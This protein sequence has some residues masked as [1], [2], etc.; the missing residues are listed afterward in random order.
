MTEATSAPLAGIRVA[1]FTWAWAGPHGTLLLAML[2]AEVIKIE[3]RTRL[4]HARVRSLMTGTLQSGPDASP[5]FNDLNLGKLSLSLNLRR[6]EAREVVRRLVA[7]SDVVTENM[8]PGVLDRL[9]L[10]YQDLRAVKPD[11]IML[12]S[13]AVGATGPESSYGGYAPTF[14][15]LSGFASITGYPDQP[16]SPLSGS[17]DLRVGA[18]CAFAVL[19]AL[20]HRQRTGEGQHIDLSSTEVMSAM[21]GEA[22]LEHS[23]NGRVPQRDGNRDPLMAPHGCYRCKG[24]EEWVSIAVGSEP[25]WHALVSVI[26]DPALEDDSFASPHQRWQHQ[27]QLDRI[28]ERWSC[29]RGAYEATRLLQQAGVA[30]APVHTGTSLAQD[31]HIRERGILER[32]EH[33]VIGERVVVGAPWKLEGA[34]VRRAAPLIGEHNQH[35]LGKVLGLSSDEIDQLEQAG[36]L[37]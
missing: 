37:E 31:P 5:V 9:G 34:G 16:P 30:A 26:A 6:P 32:V 23:M 4:D 13:S 21:M 15:S 7:V 12:S 20:H 24:E 36:A 14:A 18:T 29:E 10:G 25:E 2:G 28:V 1:D 22:F 33:P 19:A 35:V 3:S 27:E 17:V 8:R 11:I